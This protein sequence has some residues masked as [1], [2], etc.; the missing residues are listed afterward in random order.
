MGSHGANGDFDGDGMSNSYEYTKGYNPG[1]TDE[2]GDSLND[3]W[4]DYHFGDL[5]QDATMNDDGDW[6]LLLQGTLV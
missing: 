3:Y 1:N 4:E 2:D 6:A 5:T